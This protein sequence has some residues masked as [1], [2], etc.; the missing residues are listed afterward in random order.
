MIKLDK[1][2]QKYIKILTKEGEL[3][4]LMFNKQQNI[5][6]DIIKNDYKIG[7][8][9]RLIILKGRQF[10]VSTFVDSFIV[11]KLM[12][13]FNSNGLIVA[14]DSNSTNSLYKICKTGYKNLPSEL[15]PM[16]K[17]DNFNQLVFDNPDKES[18]K[19]GLN[20]SLKVAT[21]GADDIGRGMTIHYL[22]LSE[23]A[24]WRKQKEQYT[25]LMQT[26][27][28]YP[29]TLVVIESTANGFDE[30]KKIWDRAIKGENDFTAVFFSWLDFN[31]YKKEYDG[32]KLTKEEEDFM[33][34]HK[35]SLEQISWRRYAI[36]TLAGGDIDKFNQEYPTTPEDA[37]IS[38]GR[39]YFDTVLVSKFINNCKTGIKGYVS[40]N[41]F[42]KDKSSD[43]TF[44][45]FVEE[46]KP[47]VLGADTAGEGS[48][49][50][51]AY[52]IDNITSE[53]VCKYR[54][55]DDESIFTQGLNELGRY[56][57]TALISIEVNFSTYPIKT[58]DEVYRYP[59]LYVR[60]RVDTY[61]YSILKS[62][63]FRTDKRSRPLILGVLRD[64]INLN[65][66]NL[67]DR[68]LLDEIM[69]FHKDEKGK[70]VA[71]EGYHDDCIMA[72]AIT[73]YCRDQ[74]TRNI[75]IKEEVNDNQSSS[76]YDSFL[77]YG[78]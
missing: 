7:K 40:N 62:F 43:I 5:L 30:F 51:V 3:K 19:K 13:R 73:Y 37:F 71:L 16:V 34:T 18:N 52:I 50:N 17:Y 58:L 60:E 4:E 41:K 32:F 11:S 1:Y 69:T 72:A 23:F 77:N 55:L 6:Y 28:G 61:T 45:K 63:G 38:S 15:K 44:Y 21:A 12:T 31:E 48:D 47:Y 54:T 57:N 74:Q 66:Y 42:I 39:P 64:E 24:F 10:G 33:N 26:V 70:P 25:G 27:P 67:L 14:H 8:P 65:I 36:E 53:I 76:T 29:N 2:I 35:C 56:Y 9:S 22:H 49:Y 68:D 75:K 20:S 59:K 78:G 46:G